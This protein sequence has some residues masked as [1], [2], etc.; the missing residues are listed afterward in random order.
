[1][2]GGIVV[3]VGV[4]AGR[5]AIPMAL[6]CKE[7]DNGEV[8]GIDPFEAE[9]AKQDEEKIHA[10]WWERV[11]FDRVKEI[12]MECIAENEVGD[13]IQIIQ[14]RSDDVTPPPNISVYHCD[15]N[16]AS[17]ALRDVSRFSCNVKLG[18]YVVLDDVGWGSGA[19]NASVKILEEL[20]F[21]ERLRVVGQE[22]GSKFTDDFGVW[23]RITYC[24]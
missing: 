19:V 9:A 8:I 23:Q 6:A 7:C 13:H 1:M 14:H 5:S 20:G 3:E 2:G 17:T 18:G 11:P 16:H 10:D 22:Q 24:K 4:Y 12:L 21:V 15:G